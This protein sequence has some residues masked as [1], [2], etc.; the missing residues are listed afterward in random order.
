MAGLIGLRFAGF[1]IAGGAILGL[2]MAGATIGSLAGGLSGMS[3]GN[4]KLKQFEMAIEQGQFL[5]LVDVPKTRIESIKQSITK[6]HP[7]AE[8]DGIEPIL[9]TSFV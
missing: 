6:H 4:S 5:I 8:F 7:E 2:I 9:P 3:T 1:V